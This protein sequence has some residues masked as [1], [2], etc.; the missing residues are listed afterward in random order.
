M[1]YSD[2]DLREKIQ[3]AVSAAF[4]SGSAVTTISLTEQL[5]VKLKPIVKNEQQAYT[6]SQLRQM[7]TTLV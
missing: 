4:N 1:E 7:L 2:S 6:V 5:L 3:E